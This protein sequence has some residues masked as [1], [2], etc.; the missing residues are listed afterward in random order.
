MG[1]VQNRLADM[2]STFSFMASA[3]VNGTVVQCRES[4]ATGVQLENSTLIATGRTMFVGDHAVRCFVVKNGFTTCS[5][6]SH[7]V[8]T[9]TR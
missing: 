8:V 9:A 6:S 1:P 3:R 7:T 5:L 4:T 2:T